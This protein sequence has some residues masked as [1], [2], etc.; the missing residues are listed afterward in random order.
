M[1]KYC[2]GL[3][4]T[5]CC[6][7]C[8]AGCDGGSNDTEIQKITVDERG[9]P[10]RRIANP[11]FNFPIVN[12]QTDFEALALEFIDSYW[13]AMDEINITATGVYQ[14]LSAGTPTSDNSGIEIQH[15][16]S[17]LPLQ[18]C[19]ALG[20]VLSFEDSRPFCGNIYHP[21]DEGYIEVSIYN[22]F[23][24]GGPGVTGFSSITPSGEGVIWELSVDRSS[25]F[26]ILYQS[27]EGSEIRTAGCSSR[28]AAA[29]TWDIHKCAALLKEATSILKLI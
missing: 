4:A 28:D 13:D 1:S 19:F 12:D 16:D 20:D 3:V 5:I 29:E 7:L 23:A 25:D 6:S 21:V 15:L 17:F 10:F 14:N 9:I 26:G 18:E 27:T 11:G 22:S 2:L 8:I 24:D